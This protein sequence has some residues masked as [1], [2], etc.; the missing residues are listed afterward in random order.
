V[1]AGRCTDAAVCIREYSAGERPSVNMYCLPYAGGSA[2]FYHPLSARLPP[3]IALRAVQFPGRAERISDAPFQSVGEA[4]EAVAR[5]VLPH[6][7]ELPFVLFGHSMGALIAYE[8]A[9]RL[10][11]E[12]AN[13]RLVAVSASPPAT[14][15]RRQTPV[16]TMPTVELVRTLVASGGMAREVAESPELLELVLPAIRADL[17]MMQRYEPSAWPTLSCPLVAFGGDDDASVKEHDL[18]GW[19]DL[20]SMPQA[21]RTYPGGHFYLAGFPKAFVSDLV[22]CVAESLADRVSG[23]VG[24]ATADV[25]TWT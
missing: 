15:P 24:Q 14:S 3:N 11:H 17:G 18:A 2:S 25:T 4:A 9:C 20:T 13:L 6:T 21:A 5:A 23:S 16:H 7:R 8:A 1:S 10:A 19:M 22:T 12:G